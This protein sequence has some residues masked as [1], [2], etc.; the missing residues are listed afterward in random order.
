M[1]QRNRGA[2]RL[3]VDGFGRVRR[4]ARLGAA[5]SETG[6][7]S[8][9]GK[10]SRQGYDTW[11]TCVNETYGGIRVGDQRYRAEIVY[12]EAPRIGGRP[13][14]CGAGPWP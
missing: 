6:K 8:V 9:E 1:Q 11:L 13:G 2:R 5:L 7:Y 12:Y 4:T 14:P 3:A 10:D